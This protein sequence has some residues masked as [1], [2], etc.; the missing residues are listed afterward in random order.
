MSS[1]TFTSIDVANPEVP[2]VYVSVDGVDAAGEAVGNY[3]DADSDFYGFAAEG[4]TGTTFNLPQASSVAIVGVTAGGEIYGDYVNQFNGQDGFID[5]NGVVTEI[6][7]PLAS[8]TDV[9]GVA[10][11]GDIYGGYEDLTGTFQGFIDD[12][13]AYTTISVPGAAA[14][15]VYGL[16]TDGLIAG[17]FVDSSNRDHGFIDNNGAISTLDGP[18]ALD[19]F[20]VGVGPQ[21]EVVGNYDDAAGNSHGYVYANGVMTTLNVPGAVTVGIEAINDTGEIAGYYTDAQGNVHG[22]ID[23]NGSIEQVDIPGATQTDILGINDAGDIYGYYNDSTGLQHGFVGVPAPPAVSV[24]DTTTGKSVSATPT[25]YTG[26]V[27]GLQEQYIYTGR[28]SVNIT[29]NSDDWFVHGGPGNDAIAV[30]GGTNVLDGSTG[31]NFLSGGTGSDTFFVDDRSPSAP[32]W[33]T[34]NGFHAGDMAT[35]FGVTP[36]QFDLVWA[37]GEGATGYQGLTLHVL[38]GNAPTASLT[39]SGYTTA[40]LQDGRLAVTFGQEA[41]GTPYMSIVGTSDAPSAAGAFSEPSASPLNFLGSDALAN[42]APAS[43]INIW[44]DNDTVA[45]SGGDLI[46]LLGSSATIALDANGSG[47]P[48]TVVGFDEGVDHLTFSG[49]NLASETAVIGSAQLI[50]GSTVLSF[51][52]HSSIV[53]A[54]VT[55]V[56]L[57]IFA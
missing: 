30:V 10:S 14:T 56:D 8:T 31:S 55:H 52:D 46:N 53:L 37:D 26:P 49:E 11:N 32:I 41:D 21:N 20:V 12:N 5:N 17:V 47:L 42:P 29:V 48:D 38:D 6:D 51:A 7:P 24:F 15:V 3:G 27:A 44:G 23:D 22:F 19:T 25:A 40:D 45:G 2:L 9:T 33:S 13:G 43:Q 50:N 16:N 28:D 35:V 4:S 54:G 1:Y 36:G 18:G 57:G 34:M 39:L